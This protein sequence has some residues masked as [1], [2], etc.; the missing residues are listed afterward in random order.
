MSRKIVV[1]IVAS[2]LTVVAVTASDLS[3]TVY[4]SNLG[5]VS[6]V[7]SLTFEKGVHRIAFTDVPSAI[8][9]TSVQFELVTDPERVAILEQN[10]AYDLVSPD[11]I[12]QKYLD[13][14]IELIDKDGHVYSGTLLAFSGGAATLA[15]QSGG[16]KIVSMSNIAHASFPELPGGMITR[17]TLFWNYSS[18][19]SGKLNGRVS[20][21]TSGMDWQGEYVGVLDEKDRNLDLTGWASITN[22]SGKTFT[23]A[24]LRLIAGDINRAKRD[25]V[26]YKGARTAVMEMAAPAPGF[27]EKQFFEYHMYT[28]PRPATLADKEI[29]QLS[30]FD[31]AHTEVDKVYRY[32]SGMNSNKVQ[33]AI[34]FKNSEAKGLGMPLPEGRIRM[35]KADDDGTMVLL[36]EDKIN[37][38][39][40]DE[41]LN[42]NI[43]T[44]FD[45]VVEEKTAETKMISNKV[46]ETSY[47]IE[48]RNH[49]AEPIK[50]EVIKSLWGFWEITTSSL[51]YEKKDATTVKFYPEVPADGSMVIKY[52][53]RQTHR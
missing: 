27:E 44:A 18:T 5:V 6:E 29:K 23:D 53:V 21:Q 28:L 48:I 4:N 24:N 43:G 3:V 32:Q 2:L 16:I 8:D 35:F 39:P 26:L 51:E 33:V 31:P 11:K 37:H 42:I 50:V 41:E 14:Q 1:L 47:E 17:P 12:Y 52:T 49:K 13:K 10:Y 45:I 36:G 30:L 15:D 19:V 9:A 40:K 46:E 38:T 22:N 25:D 34:K 20:Y 7:R